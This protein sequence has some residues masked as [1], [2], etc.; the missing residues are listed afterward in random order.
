MEQ[1]SDVERLFSWLKT[2]DL[3]YREFAASR[4]VADAVATWPALH[5]AAGEAGRPSEAAAPE[6]GVAARERLERERMTLPPAAAEAIRAG[7]AMA[8]PPPPLAGGRL[9]SALG[10]RMQGARHAEAEAGA[11]EP[12]G[13]RPGYGRAEEREAQDPA[14]RERA[15]EAAERLRE[16]LDAAMAVNPRPAASEGGPQPAGEAGTYRAARRAPA[17]A[18]A[19][20]TARGGTLFGGA[21]RRAEPEPEPDRAENLAGVRRGGHSLQAVFTRLS[22]ARGRSLPDPRDRA[23]SSPGLGSIFNRLR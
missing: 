17:G 3:R 1:T 9:I 7:P 16:R 20:R 10:R 4:E 21:Y 13:P 8:S 19:P 11:A 22:T 6:G 2:E 18:A 14:A 5:K 12:T 23:R 15:R